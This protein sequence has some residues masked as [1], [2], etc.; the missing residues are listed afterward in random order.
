[1]KRT[2]LTRIRA[3]REKRREIV[4]GCGAAALAALPEPDVVAVVAAARALARQRQ[5]KL[6]PE[7]GGGCGRQ[8][9]DGRVGVVLGGEA[10]AGEEGAGVAQARG[11]LDVANWVVRSVCGGAAAAQNTA[12]I[13]QAVAAARFPCRACVSRRRGARAAERQR[14]ELRG[15]AVVEVLVEVRLRLEVLVA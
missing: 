5:A 3:R 13:G 2:N 1:M 11:N 7:L 15:V 14:T 10:G 12:V 9:S 8:L 4:S 6:A